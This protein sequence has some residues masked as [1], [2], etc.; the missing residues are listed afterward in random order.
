MKHEPHDQ[1]H[2]APCERVT[3]RLA[4]LVDGGLSP[5][6]EARDR[7]HLEACAS[8]AEA[9]ADWLEFHRQLTAALPTVELPEDLV[10]GLAEK[11]QAVHI[12][13]P[14]AEARARVWTSLVAAAASLVVLF[15]FEALGT[16]MDADREGPLFAPAGLEVPVHWP[17]EGGLIPE[18]LGDGVFS[19]LKNLP[20][21]SMEDK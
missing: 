12:K 16:A 3:A 15:G 18:D 10:P 11:L 6:D 2:A 21:E 7:G 8:C 20:S 4:E 13:K 19:D 14:E 9:F 17:A 5:L 1:V